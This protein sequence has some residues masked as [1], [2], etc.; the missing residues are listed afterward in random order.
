MGYASS[1][2]KEQQDWTQVIR[3]QE[4]EFVLKEFLLIFLPLLLQI[5]HLSTVSLAQFFECCVHLVNMP[6]TVCMYGSRL[7]V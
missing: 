1:K 7:S 6:E 4:D 5:P 3:T 2:R